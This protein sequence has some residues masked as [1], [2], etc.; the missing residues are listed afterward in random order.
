MRLL[1]KHGVFT[2]LFSRWG[3]NIGSLQISSLLNTPTG[4]QQVL[5]WQKNETQA[6]VWRNTGIN[7]QS[8]PYDFA[9]KID[10]FVGS[11]WEGDVC[12]LDFDS[13]KMDEIFHFKYLRLAS[14]NS[15][16]PMEPVHHQLSAISK[17]TIVVGSMIRP[18]VSIGFVDRKQQLRVV[19]AQQQVCI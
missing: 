1:L 13:M 19:L 8:V 3:G 18:L 17:L 12:R 14:M 11:G 16:S 2:L 4:Q 10:G 5:L 15:I 9:L 7:L 6:R